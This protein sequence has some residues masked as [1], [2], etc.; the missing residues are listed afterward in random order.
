MRTSVAVAVVMPMAERV[1]QV[2]ERVLQVVE[3]VVVP[4]PVSGLAQLP[5]RPLDLPAA[6]RVLR[7]VEGVVDLRERARAD[8]AGPDELV[9]LG[10]RDRHAQAILMTNW[11]DRRA[12]SQDI[13]LLAERMR[14]SQK[15][16]TELMQGWLKDRGVKPRDARDHRG[17]DHGSGGRTFRRAC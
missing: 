2:L 3:R 11:V 13:P 17:H 4:Q 9:E 7:G 12:A 1:G 15:S 8:E 5:L 6:V 14:I 10:T 16:E